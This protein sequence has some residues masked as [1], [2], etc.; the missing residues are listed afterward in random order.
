MAGGA[1]S[2]IFFRNCLPGVREEGWEQTFVA[3]VVRS[4]LIFLDGRPVG[5]PASDQIVDSSATYGPCPALTL[6]IFAAFTR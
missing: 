4:Y 2:L 1:L 5:H 3:F 6:Q